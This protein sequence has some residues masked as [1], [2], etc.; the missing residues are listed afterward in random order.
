MCCLFVIAALFGPRFLGFIWWLLDPVR[1]GTTFPEPLFG[2]IGWLIVPWT[3]IAY[4]FTF[5][6]GIEGLDWALIAL[7]LIVDLSTNGGGIFGRDR[8][9]RWSERR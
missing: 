2:L 1:W 5:P 9:R 4:M 3:T 7:A 8:G 6:G